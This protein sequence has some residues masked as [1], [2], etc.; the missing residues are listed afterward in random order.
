MYEKHGY[1]FSYGKLAYRQVCLHH[2]VSEL[3]Y[4]PSTNIPKACIKEQLHFFQINICCIYFT[5][6]GRL[7]LHRSQVVYQPGAYPGFCGMKRLGVFLPTGWDC[8]PSQG[9]PQHLS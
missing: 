9:Y 7:S 5:N 1:L 4:V 6:V 8:S 3:V 2:C